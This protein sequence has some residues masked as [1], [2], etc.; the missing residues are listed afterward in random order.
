MFTGPPNQ[1]YTLAPIPL[2]AT[3]DSNLPVSITSQT[4]AVCSVN[5]TS[6]A[7]LSAGQCNLAAN[8]SGDANYLLAT[9]VPQSFTIA[10]TVPDAPTIG[11]ATPGVGQASIAF[12]P[13]ANTGGVPITAY[14]VTCNPGGITG[15][16]PSSPIAIGGLANGNTYACSVKAANGVGEGAASGTVNAMPGI[17]PAFTSAGSTAFTVYTTGS[18]TVVASGTPSATLSMTGALPSGVTFNAATGVL[19]GPPAGTAAALIR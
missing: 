5:G 7:M 14:N 9:Q 15:T 8:Q 3:S 4:T 1:S 13:P 12:T 10:A 2:V 11:A 18:F 16:G 17:P 6:L 19:S